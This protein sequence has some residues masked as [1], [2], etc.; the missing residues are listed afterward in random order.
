MFRQRRRTDEDFQ[1]E[2]ESHLELEEEQLRAEGLSDREARHAARRAFGNVTRARERFYESHRLVWVDQFRQDLHYAWRMLRKSPGF[3]AVAVL[4][5]ALGIGASTALFSVVDCLLLRPLPYPDG[6]RLAVIWSQPPEGFVSS[7]SPAN[8][9]DFRDQSHSFERM[10]AITQADFNVRIHGMAERLSGFKATADLFDTL[11]MKPVLG[12]SFT[13][14]DDRPGAPR[15]AMLSYGAWQR[16]FGGDPRVAGRTL[17]VDGTPCTI[18]G[19]TP[20]NFRFIFGPEMWLPLALDPAAAPRDFHVLAVLGK[21]KRGVSLDQAR[22]ELKGIARNL[23]RAYPKFLK[24][25][26]VDPWPWRENIVNGDRRTVLVPFGAIG[27]VLLLACINLANLL[28]ARATVRRRELAVRASLGALRSRLIRQ[29][30]TETVLISVMGGAAGVLLAHFLTPL[31]ATL[32]SPP[33][34]AGVPEVGIDWRVLGFGLGL[35]VVTGLL[36]GIAPAWKASNVNLHSTLKDT[37]RT[38]AGGGPASRLRDALVALEIALSLIVLVGAGLMVRRLAALCSPDPGFHPG[39]V[40]TMRLTMPEARYAD[41]DRVRAFDRLLLDR[42]RS[43]PGVRAATIAFSMPLEGL[44]IPMRFQVVPH[45]D[46]GAARPQAAFRYASDGYFETLGIAL[47]KGRLFTERD[48]EFAPR[49]VIVNEAFV[50]RFLSKTDPL[51]QQLLLEEQWLSGKP[52]RK[53]SLPWE[54][55]GVVTNAKLWG[56]DRKG[57]PQLYAPLMQCPQPGGVLAVSMNSG[58]GEKVPTIRALIRGLDQD[59]SVTDIRTMEQIAAKSVAG[60]RSQV[61]MVC[62]F[63]AVAL[64]LSALGIYGVISYTVAQR[65]Q[66]IGIRMALGAEPRKLLLGML[67]R[68]MLLAAAGLGAGLAGA[69]AFT[70]V[71]RTLIYNAE[72][73]DPLTYVTVLAVLLAVAAL[74]TYV[75]ARRASQIDPSISLRWE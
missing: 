34:L 10:G 37:T 7:M 11:G 15:V 53:P 61:W 6:D 5:L 62:S 66:E 30:L 17:N 54:V 65:T 13:A 3:T 29:G 16:R 35:S 1:A 12:R 28:L 23:A 59:V 64:I 56:M 39:N 38:S 36:F 48:N 21:L 47:R 63:A 31:A 71:L 73:T 57:S 74:A 60:P 4:T 20:S 49:V 2:I 44:A 26:S 27:M 68:G 69:F 52:G 75:P 24:G 72:P 33:I 22:T 32:V 8:F 67:R 55:I 70:R 58:G 9:L 51:G 43:V 40:I 18:I 42:V 45:A 41:L 50:R 46:Q 25:W 14:A 19:V